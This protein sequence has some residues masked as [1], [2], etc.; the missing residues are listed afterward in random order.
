[1]SFSFKIIPIIRV[2]TSENFY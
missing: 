1:M 2:I